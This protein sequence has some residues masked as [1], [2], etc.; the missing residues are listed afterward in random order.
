MYCCRQIRQTD[1]INC[2]Y[3]IAYVPADKEKDPQLQQCDGQ[4]ASL[5]TCELPTT[6]KDKGCVPRNNIGLQW[7]EKL[8]FSSCLVGT[9]NC[10]PNVYKGSTATTDIIWICER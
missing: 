7:L 2:K 8:L 3:L 4:P 9:K 5:L 6:V 10:P 1:R